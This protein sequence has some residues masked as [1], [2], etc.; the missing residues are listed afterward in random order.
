V[1]R[2]DVEPTK[3]SVAVRRSG[4]SFD[5]LTRDFEFHGF[6][7]AVLELGERFELDV[8]LDKAVATFVEKLHP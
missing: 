4:S 2:S 6:Q 5:Q 7:E 8:A 3:Y 1:R